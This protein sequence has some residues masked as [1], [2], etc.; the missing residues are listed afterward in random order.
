MPGSVRVSVL[1]R[2]GYKCVFCG[3]NSKEVP[4]EVDHIIPF[5]KGGSHD[6]SNL[7]T[8][9]FDCNRGKGARRLI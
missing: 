9:C 1:H 3:R 6:L 4:L 2:D 8:L 5:V 7:Q